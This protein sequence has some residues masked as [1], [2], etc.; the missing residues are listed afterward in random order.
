MREM[1]GVQFKDRKIAE[2]LML[3]LGLNVAINHLAM[4]E[5]SLVWSCVENGWLCHEKGIGV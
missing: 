4:A 3:G 5:C 2:D 1:C